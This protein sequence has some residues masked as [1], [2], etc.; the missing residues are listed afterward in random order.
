MAKKQTPLEALRRA[1][2]AAGSQEELAKRLS[3]RQSAISN[4]VVRKQRVPA[5]RVVQVEAAVDGAVKRHELRPDLYPSEGRA[6]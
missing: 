2:D 5:E 1:I 4:W 6:A 3:L